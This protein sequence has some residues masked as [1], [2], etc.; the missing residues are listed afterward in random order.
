M[1]YV[2]EQK[3]ATAKIWVE[4]GF[5]RVIYLQNTEVTTEIKKEHHRAYSELAHYSPIPLILEFEE[6][7]SVSHE[8]RRFSKKI[9]NKL[10]F[11][12]CAVVVAN[13]PHRILANFYYRFYGPKKPFRV[14][15]TVEEAKE[16]L[17]QYKQN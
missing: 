16:W 13:L 6:G 8:A 15:D 10:P 2:P 3:T 12:A 4:D 1:N 14:F 9:E 7:V 5:L 11:N 17:K